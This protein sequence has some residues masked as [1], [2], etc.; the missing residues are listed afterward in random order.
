MLRV[1]YPKAFEAV[2][3]DAIDTNASDEKEY[4][5]LAP[6]TQTKVT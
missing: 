1:N 6:N 3:S 4:D 2:N 5:P